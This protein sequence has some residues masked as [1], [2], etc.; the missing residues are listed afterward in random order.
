ML[1][2][3]R[4]YFT[5]LDQVR[6]LKENTSGLLGRVFGGS[7]KREEHFNM[8]TVNARESIKTAPPPI[9]ESLKR[10]NTSHIPILTPSIS[11]TI[12]QERRVLEYI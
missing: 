5:L 4:Q 6:K 12:T 2:K 3:L 10:E 9:P 1:M 8:E 7:R 11:S